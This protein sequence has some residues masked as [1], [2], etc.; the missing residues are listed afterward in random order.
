VHCFHEKANTLIECIGDYVLIEIVHET[1]LWS[2]LFVEAISPG[3]Q[4]GA[5]FVANPS[6]A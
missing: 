2:K 5:L 1:V 6:A 3:E 4:V